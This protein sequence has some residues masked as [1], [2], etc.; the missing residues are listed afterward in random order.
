[1]MVAASG[2]PVC[3]LISS[4]TDRA[5]RTRAASESRV[6]NFIVQGMWRG[7]KR[8]ECRALQAAR[9]SFERELKIERNFCGRIDTV[10][11][12]RK[13]GRQKEGG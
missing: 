7:K 2:A 13:K 10:D 12:K 3:L 5:G 9:F 4:G 8:M 1:V 6:A 11:V